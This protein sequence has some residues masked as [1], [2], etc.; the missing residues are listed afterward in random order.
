MVSDHRY[1]GSVTVDAH[2]DIALGHGD[3]H[4]A[5]ENGV[6]VDDECVSSA[7]GCISFGGVRSSGDCESIATFPDLVGQGGLATFDD[8]ERVTQVST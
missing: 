4:L 1:R 5:V 7:I 8:G 3:G 6:A 2:G